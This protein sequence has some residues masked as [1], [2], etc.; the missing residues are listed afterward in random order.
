MNENSSETKILMANALKKLIK[1]RPF[2]KITVQDIVSECNINRNTFYYHFENNYDLLYFAYSQEVQFIVDSFH[3]AKASIPKAMDFVLDYID[4]N[5]SLCLCAYESL[6]EKQ[7]RTIVEKD[8]FT[9]ARGTIEFYAQA[10]GVEFSED[11]KTFVGYSYSDLLSSQ[12]IWYIKHSGDLDKEKFK[13]YF[14]TFFTATLKSILE[15][16]ANKGF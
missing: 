1:D 4:K 12:I 9:F 16:A 15:E 14:Q 8:L 13:D 6:G 3:E 2:S 7:L 10:N 11:F 5:S